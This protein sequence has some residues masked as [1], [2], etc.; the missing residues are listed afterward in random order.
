MT[1]MSESPESQV[2]RPDQLLFELKSAEKALSVPTGN[3]AFLGE[4]F[5]EGAVRLE[6]YFSVE[7][8]QLVMNASLAEVAGIL[9]FLHDELRNKMSYVRSPKEMITALLDHGADEN[10]PDVAEKRIIIEQNKPLLAAVIKL[11]EL[12]IQPEFEVAFM[13]LLETLGQEESEITQLSAELNKLSLPEITE[14]TDLD[15]AREEVNAFL[16]QFMGILEKVEKD[17][18]EKNMFGSELQIIRSKADIDKIMSKGARLSRAGL[19][20]IKD[21]LLMVCEA[22]LKRKKD[23]YKLYE[24][25]L[26]VLLQEARDLHSSA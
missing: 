26:P 24:L 3:Y 9:N 25:E 6:R 15:Q 13:A 23:T 16:T 20:I 17:L 18:N 10:D 14:T 19:R 22:V 4:G 8:G 12:M 7:N 2:P 21:D 11:A 5:S 1:I